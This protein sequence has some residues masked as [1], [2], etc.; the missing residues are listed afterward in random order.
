MCTFCL[1]AQF[2]VFIIEKQ[3]GF[4]N[5]KSLLIGWSMFYCFLMFNVLSVWELSNIVVCVNNICH[6]LSVI[7]SKKMGEGVEFVR[8]YGGKQHVILIFAYNYCMIVIMAVFLRFQFKYLARLINFSYF[9]IF[10]NQ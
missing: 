10:Y 5:S 1:R 7:A 9:V 3:R 6:F 8:M 4:V 2:T